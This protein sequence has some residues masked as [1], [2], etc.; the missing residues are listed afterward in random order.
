MGER[1][2]DS[3]EPEIGRD[4][5]LLAD[6]RSYEPRD[7]SEGPFVHGPSA[8]STGR[9]TQTEPI[10]S[11][12][13]GALFEM[14]GPPEP[15]RSGLNNLAKGQDKLDRVCQHWGLRQID[16]FFHLLDLSLGLL[17]PCVSETLCSNLFTLTF[18]SRSVSKL[19]VANALNAAIRERLEEQRGP[20]Q[21]T[22][23]D[24]EAV[25][26]D[27]VSTPCIY[28]VLAMNL[29][30]HIAH[31]RSEF[32]TE[33]WVW[34]RCSRPSQEAKW[35]KA[36]FRGPIPDFVSGTGFTSGFA[37]EKS[38]CACI[39]VSTQPHRQ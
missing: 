38:Q 32:R 25:M 23:E 21:L 9:D 6:G 35:L 17:Q 24:I 12:D 8:S 28:H 39:A 15:N 34:I 27:P 26:D 10:V 14:S 7:L 16:E 2:V 4:D 20:R 30:L 13:Q 29:T 5:V 1:G 31:L 19:E 36:S 22:C 18:A 33:P 11:S 3:L 37:T